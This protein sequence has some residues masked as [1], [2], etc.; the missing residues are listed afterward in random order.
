MFLSRAAKLRIQERFDALESAPRHYVDPDRVSSI[1]TDLQE[2]RL[3]A[4]T[5]HAAHGGSREAFEARLDS[6]TESIAEL[7]TSHTELIHAV[8]EG[9]SRTERAERRIRGT[10]QRARKELKARGYDD[11]G[12]EAEDR[13]FREVD[14]NG[15]SPGG[16]PFVPETVGEA[17]DEA[18]T[19]RGVSL[20]T[21]KRFRG[22][23]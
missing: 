10:I 15:G 17:R 16:V 21:M 13:E 14:E 1:E 22:M 18:S 2:L 23:G 20:E 12:L 6:L 7:A 11:P 8:D 3:M 9:I 4:Q 19:I 5:D